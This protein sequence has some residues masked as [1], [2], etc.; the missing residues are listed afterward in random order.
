MKFRAFAL[1]GGDSRNGFTKRPILA[2]PV[3][4][5]KQADHSHKESNRNND[6]NEHEEGK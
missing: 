3:V 4:L 6:A 1:L 5:E 2:S